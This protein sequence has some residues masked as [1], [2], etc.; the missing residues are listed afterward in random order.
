M[1]PGLKA[2]YDRIVNP[3]TGKAVMIP[4]DHGITVGPIKGIVDPRQTVRAAV[5]GKADCV[6]FNQGLADVLFPEYNT[7]IG[8]IHILTNSCTTEEAT[9]FGSVERAV[10][11]AADA[12]SVIIMVGSEYE[13]RMIEMGRV[14]VDACE[15]WNM[16]SL[17]MMYPTDEYAAKLGK[18]EAVAH[19]ARAGAELGATIVKT[20]WV[21]SKAAMAKVVEGCPAPMVVAGGGKKPLEDT[22]QMV[23]DCI[24]VGAIGIAMGRNAWGSENPT[25]MVTALHNLVQDGAKVKEAVIVYNDVVAKTK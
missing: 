9:L 16:P 8:A 11:Y 25:A 23:R 13:R 2:R 12:V 7:K 5:A 6:M 21:G 18:P 24:D 17:F 22:F 19:V 3:V 14:V 15:Q 10:K 1:H 20:A 4:F